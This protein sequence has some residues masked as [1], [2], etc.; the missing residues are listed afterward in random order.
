M[1][2]SDTV[3]TAWKYLVN[4]KSPYKGYQ[5]DIGKEYLFD[6][7][8]SDEQATCAAGGNV[9]TLAWCLR[10][11]STADEFIKVEFQVKDIAAI[12]FAT[13]GKFRLRRFKVLERVNREQAIALLDQLIGE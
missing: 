10:D 3:L 8:D 7:A 9:A 11:S 5:Y 4:G 12:P 13:D 1:Q 2:D 6:D